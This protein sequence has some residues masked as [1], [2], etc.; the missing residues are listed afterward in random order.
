MRICLPIWP[1][2]IMSHSLTYHGNHI[3]SRVLHSDIMGSLT[4]AA[5][6]TAGTRQIFDMRPVWQISWYPLM[7][8]HTGMRISVFVDAVLCLSLRGHES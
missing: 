2:Y 7:A 1:Y 6:E 3:C 5:T 4:A 8:L